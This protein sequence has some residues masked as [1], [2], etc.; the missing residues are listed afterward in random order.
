MGRPILFRQMRVGQF[1]REFTLAKFRSMR[2]AYDHCSEP[3]PDAVRITAIGRILRRYRL[4]ELPELWQI[5]VGDMSF[6]GPRPLPKSLIASDNLFHD[7][8]RVRPGLTGLA[9]VS[10]NTLLSNGEKFAIDLYYVDHQSMVGDLGIV[11]ATF[12]MIAR[13]EHRNEP[14]IRK[15]LQYA[16]SVNRRSR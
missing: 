3:L 2:D 12:M 15:A 14:I 4:D 9:Q 5:A 1:G 6:V 10:G 8:C 11:F 16:S 13:G 7:R